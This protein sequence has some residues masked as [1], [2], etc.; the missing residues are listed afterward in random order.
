MPGKHWRCFL[1]QLS[2][3]SGICDQKPHTSSKDQSGVVEAIQVCT[4]GKF[5][6]VISSLFATE[7]D[8]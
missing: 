5:V 4:C 6:W 3:R 8:H 2:Q 1:V 7:F